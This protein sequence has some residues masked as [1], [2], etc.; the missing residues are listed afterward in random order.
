MTCAADGT[1]TDA[2]D[3]DSGSGLIFKEEKDGKMIATIYGMNSW[4]AMPC[5]KNGRPGVYARVTGALDWISRYTKIQPHAGEAEV[6]DG[7]MENCTSGLFGDADDNGEVCTP[8]QDSD[9]S[10]YSSSGSGY[11]DSGR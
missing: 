5:A 2:S 4:S 10:S 8:D 1:G 3:G 9:S 7:C 11:S 6:M